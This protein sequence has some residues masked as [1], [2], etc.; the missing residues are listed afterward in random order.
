[1]TIK[2]FLENTN[3]KHLYH[4]TD[5]RNLDSIKSYGLLSSKELLRRG[6]SPEN[7][8]GN[9]VSQNAD[10]KKGV[11]AYVHLC[12][13]D[14]HP[15]EYQKRQERHID[16]TEFLKISLDVLDFDGVMGCCGVANKTGVEILPIKEA[17]GLMD[18]E[19][20]FGDNDF[21][22]NAFNNCR[23]D[24]ERKEIRDLR[25]RYN[26]AKKYEILI[27]TEIPFKLIRR[28]EKK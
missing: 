1:M 13:K 11:D 4:F 14:Q 5:V 9:I 8:G 19:I 6:I 26:E 7:P 18:L 2:N 16:E 15:M 23:N 24:D 12:F 27:P 22:K 3:I 25:E 28:N 20:L 17:L 21:S 10:S